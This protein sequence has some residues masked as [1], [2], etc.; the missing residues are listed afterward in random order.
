MNAEQLK[1]KLV[2]KAADIGID[3]IGFA[4]ADPFL[5]LKERLREQQ[6]RGYASGFE[7]SDIEL[8]THPE[9]LVPSV[10]T[11]IAIAI[12][13]PA[14]LKNPPKSEP[15][16]YRGIFCRASWGKDYHHVLKDKLN[17]LA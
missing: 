3:K 9:K 15:D 8:R 16:N 12:A 7:E 13:Y 4:S 2:Q 10:K 5:E 1:E 6:S 11:I 14:K 17:Q